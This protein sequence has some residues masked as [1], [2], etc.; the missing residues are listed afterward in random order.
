[1]IRCQITNGQAARDED[2]WLRGLSPEAD[3]IQIRE[4]DLTTR[5]LAELVRRVLAMKP[6]ARILVNDRLDVALAT[7]AAGVH[8]KSAGISPEAV[9][10]ITPEGFLITVACHNEA[11]V[12]NA[13]GADY[14]LLAPIFS[15]LSKA[16]DRVPLGLTELNRIAMI[17]PT[18]IL[19]LGGITAFNAS[20]CAEAGAAGIAGISLYR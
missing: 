19:A 12:R 9:R 17:S 3:L 1:M 10:T 18:P 15:P 5:H 8:L 4:P 20:L 16:E 14:A 11:D 6:G 7:G 2:A 13:K